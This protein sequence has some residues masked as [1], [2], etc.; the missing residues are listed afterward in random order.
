MGITTN[1]HEGLKNTTGDLN[2]INNAS[3]GDVIIKGNDGGSTIT[4]LTLDMS[5]LGNA[6]FNAG[7]KGPNGGYFN[8]QNA[9]G[10]STYPVYSFQDDAN[11]GMMSSSADTLSLVTGGT[12]RLLLS[13][14]SAT[15][16]G[17]VSIPVAKRLYFG[18]GSH[19]YIVEDVDDRL[20]FVCG[21]DEHIRF[22]DGGNGDR[23][24]F[25][26]PT[27]FALAATFAGTVNINNA[28]ADKKM[29]FDRTGGKGI[30]I[31]HDANGIYFYNETDSSVMFRM[32]NAGNI[33]TSGEVEGGSLDING[34]A[35]I[36]GT[37][38]GGRVFAKSYYQGSSTVGFLIETSIATNNYAM[39]HGT[40]K[41]EQ[42]NNSTFQTIE[43]S[44]TLQSNGTVVTKAGVANIAITIKLFNYNGMWYI[45][46]PQ[47]TTYTTCTAY[48]STANS[49][50]GQIESF[51]EVASVQGGA[52]PSSGVTNSTD[53]VTL[54][55]ATT[56][57]VDA[58]TWNGNDITSGV[59]ASAYLDSDTMHLSVTQNISAH[60]EFNDNIQLRFGNDADLKIQHTGSHGYLDC[61]TGNMYIRAE[62]DASHI[63]IQA[64]NGSGANATYIDVDGD[65][66]LILLSKPL[67]I[68]TGATV[69][70]ILDEDA[71][72]SNSATALATQQSI[73]AY[74]TASVSAAG[75]GDV[76]LAGAQTF[77][78][79]KTFTG[80]V[81]LTGTG[82]ITGIDTVSS[83]TDAANKTYV[84]GLASNYATSAQGTLATNALPKAGGTMTGDIKLNDN[85]E[86]EFGTG[87]D[88]KMKFDGADLITT[89][90]AGSAFMV[91]TN[92][93]TP[94]DNSGKADF[95]VD[96]NGAPQISLYSDQVQI[97]STDMNWSSKFYYSGGTFLASWDSNLTLF[98]Q[99][100]SGAS[101]KNIILRP[102]AADGA[103]TTVATFNGDTGTT[104]TGVVTLGQ[105]PTSN[106][107]AATKAYVDGAVIANTDT[108]DLSISG[109]TL[110]LTNGGSVTVGNF[111]TGQELTSINTIVNGGNRYNPSTNNPTNEHYAVL[112]YGNAGNVTG[113]LATHFQTGATYNRAYNSGWSA[114]SR[115]FDDDYHPNAD[116]LT[117]ARNI[118]GVSF[119]GSASINLPGVNAT[120][121]QNTSGSSGSCTG[122]A[123]TATKISSIT[124]SN[125]VQLATTTTQ[126]GTK[127]FSGV[128]DITN[129]TASSNATGDTGAL[130]CEGG[131][132]IAG[133]IY[134]GSTITGSADVIA[135]S[136]RKLKENI[137]TLDGKKVL[138]MRGVSFTRKDTG[139]ESSGV[140][141]QEIQ[142]V[143]P[144]LVH[145][146][147]GTLGVAYGNLVGYL[148]EAVKDQQKQIDELK[149]MINGNS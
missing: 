30:S 117:T 14:A 132:S 79:A 20:R 9:A 91:G 94:H 69:S 10:N 65:N 112:T 29:S 68:G 107:H 67:K 102:Q 26:R 148:I 61:E 124:N 52:V 53:L 72:G 106:L 122:N 135:F 42:F 7:L 96:V 146:T 31:E 47:T 11:T 32:Y 104:F 63:Y 74:V 38:T 60:K 119:N 97:G 138:D 84:D 127:T 109:T 83:G 48:V 5:N 113:Q 23:T 143:A 136:D 90:P 8:I 147:E 88:V 145:D 50:Q 77:T 70:T 39:I 111:P 1:T 114:W 129:T 44:A 28:G 51:N 128:I 54:V 140:I 133:K 62:T 75:G 131:A 134:A 89:V 108:Q 55:K 105:A 13:N 17:D 82:R 139:A 92:G 125:I 81:A 130:R 115:M 43:F 41:L 98:T 101:A 71:M 12:A 33:Q 120:G 126:T 40:I 64:D 149:A 144:E 4:A 123:A 24:D 25:Y 95:V 80:T 19:T 76:T 93:G 100:S 35:D 73:K 78:G 103:I 49:Y 37:L 34:N 46:V 142:K 22:T 118:G 110:S 2:I 59:V 36:S 27:Y 56:A 15:F 141:A 66:E 99:G 121:N 87:S 86:V 3:D 137:Q 58:K 45:W 85:V 16:A 6:T 18:G 57:Y 21:G 116:V